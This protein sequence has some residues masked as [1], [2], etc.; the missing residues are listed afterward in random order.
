MSDLADVEQDGDDN[1]SFVTQEG[2]NLTATV[3]QLT[4][5]NFS[6]VTQGGTGNSIV[7][8]Q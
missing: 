5:G 6:S 4:N 3:N 7:V 8:N 2:I 1:T